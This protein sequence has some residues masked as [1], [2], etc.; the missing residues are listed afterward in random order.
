MN[1]QAPGWYPD[2]SGENQE[3]Y[4]DGDSWTEYYRPLLP[5]AHEPSGAESAHEDYPYLESVTRKRPDVMVSPGTPG[6]WQTSAWGTPDEGRTSGGTKVFGSGVRGTPGGVAAVASL[7]VLAL[8][9]ITGIGWWALAG[10][11][12]PDAPTPGPGGGSG[13][14]STG[15]LMLGEETSAQVASGSRW[16]GELAVET[17]A[18]LLLDVRTESGAED[19]QV[20]VTDAAGNE[21]AAGDDRGRELA[22]ELAGSSLD[23]F[24]AVSLDPGEYTVA[25]TELDGMASD[26]AV[27]ATE[28]TDEVALDQEST[29]SVPA[30]GPWVGS[31]ELPDAGEYVVDVQD[32]G[33]GDPVLLT[34]DGE[35]RVRSND[36]RDPDNEDR[37]PLLESEFAA[38]TLVLIVTE[39]SGE[40]TD[41]TVTVSGS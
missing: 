10:R 17:P 31:V 37:D 9:L 13:G 3:R 40:A 16:E 14:A 5:A 15:T 26:F 25:V 27:S 19:L 6:G 28:V 32:T 30:G 23:P 8:L 1:E 21:V 33:T 29:V 7:V 39:W 34:L 22:E 24:V 2:P 36:D 35:G 11:R 41:V 18:V 38:G 20:V 12:E 4:W